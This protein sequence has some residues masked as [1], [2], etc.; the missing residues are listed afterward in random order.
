MTGSDISSALRIGLALLIAWAA[1]VPLAP[2]PAVMLYAFLIAVG[3]DI[4]GV[5]L[6]R[7]HETLHGRVLDSL[8]DKALV[9]AVL[10]PMA[11]RGSPPSILLVALL[12]RDAIAVAVQ[13]IAARR[14]VALPVGR[15]GV[16][17][18]ALLYVACAALLTL[19][20]I[21]S[22]SGPVTIDPGDL[23]TLLLYLGIFQ[24][25]LGVGLVLSF[26]TLYRYILTLRL[27]GS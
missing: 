20:W 12:G 24:L 1:T 16:V 22:G 21:Q 23:G 3:T 5:L 9:Y 14:G 17:K 10:I 27:S 26:V 2:G 18:T 19:G 11:S 4:A 13:V 8:A 25:A 6:T 15:S 7:G